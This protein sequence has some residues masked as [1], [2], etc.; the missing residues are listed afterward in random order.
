MEPWDN[1]VI[2]QMEMSPGYSEKYWTGLDA[3]EAKEE[4]VLK[5]G[6]AAKKTEKPAK[7]EEAVVKEEVVTPAKTTTSVEQ[8]AK[9][10]KSNEGDGEEEDEEQGEKKL[11]KLNKKANRKMRSVSESSCAV[12][13]EQT[14]QS[15][16]PQQVD[17]KQQVRKCRSVSE[18]SSGDHLNSPFQ[19]KSILKRRAF[20]RSISE[21]SVDEQASYSMSFDMGVGSFDNIPEES[22]EILSE[23]CKKTVHFSDVI[24]KQLFR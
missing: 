6:I 18:S 12:T 15:S 1:N 22:D 2:L 4:G 3:S 11:K 23:S 14:K 5:L 21:S 8:T 17:P 10:V 9:E 16:A 24:R 13:E 7:K 19:F 20:N